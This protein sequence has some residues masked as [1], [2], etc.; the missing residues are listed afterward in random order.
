MIGGRARLAAG[1]LGLLLACGFFVANRGVPPRHDASELAAAARGA[2]SVTLS[3]AGGG[4]AAGDSILRVRDIGAPLFDRVFGAPP[5]NAS[6][7]RWG[8]VYPGEFNNTGWWDKLEASYQEGRWLG[9]ACPLAAAMDAIETDSNGSWTQWVEVYTGDVAGIRLDLGPV[10]GENS[11]ENACFGEDR[12]GNSVCTSCCDGRQVSCPG[13]YN[14]KKFG[15]RF[16]GS[17]ASPFPAALAGGVLHAVSPAYI[18]RKN[19]RLTGIAV[20]DVEMPPENCSQWID[21]PVVVLKNGDWMRGASGNV[22]HW[23]AEIFGVLLH[24]AKLLNA[25]KVIPLIPNCPIRFPGPTKICRPYVVGYQPLPLPHLK[26]TYFPEGTNWLFDAPR[27]YDIPFLNDMTFVPQFDPTAVTC[28]RRV[29]MGCPPPRACPAPKY[30]STIQPLYQAFLRSQYGLD[31]TQP[32]DPG[33]VLYLVNRRPL[34]SR[35]I[36]NAAE[37]VD[38]AREKGWDAGGL[39]LWDTKG[40]P[41]WKAAQRL[42]RAAVVAGM[43]GADL[44]YAIIFLRRGSVVVETLLRH[45]SREDPWYVYQAH[46]ARV[47]AVRWLVDHR[48][49]PEWANQSVETQTERY[50]N[51][52]SWRRKATN[53]TLPLDGWARVLRRVGGIYRLPQNTL[54]GMA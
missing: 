11:S 41:F 14:P 23:L 25:R 52:I 36:A 13:Q 34:G 7:E 45:A 15:R 50:S 2:D 17:M 32:A 33:R 16:R 54:S 6:G 29:V 27:R 3:L 37:M 8:M 48:Q 53:F 5:G 22:A 26:A 18:P 40:L 31:Y 42:Q 35:Y 24:A 30:F 39:E 4:Y 51:N 19:L 9:G 38:A 12:A 21:A 10:A 47:H 28:F 1:T 49:V 43:H 44:G 20:D 46:G